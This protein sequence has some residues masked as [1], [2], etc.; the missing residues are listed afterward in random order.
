M[1]IRPI[2]MQ[3]SNLDARTAVWWNSLV[4]QEIIFSYPVCKKK[5]NDEC[6]TSYRLLLC[7]IRKVSSIAT[8][9]LIYVRLYLD[10]AELFSYIL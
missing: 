8:K 3:L 6:I 5:K 4:V 7:F 9:F 2:A 10:M 1:K